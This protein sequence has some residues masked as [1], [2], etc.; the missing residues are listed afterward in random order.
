MGG[1][2]ALLRQACVA[3]IL[4]QVGCFV[5]AK[6]CTLHPVDHAVYALGSRSGQ[7]PR[8]PQVHS[9]SELLSGA[10]SILKERLPEE[11]WW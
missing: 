4:A 7:D 8:A 6:S 3:A 9:W 10:A 1:K 2:S 11:A 5:K